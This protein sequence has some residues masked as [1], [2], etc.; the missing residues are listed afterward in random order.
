MV[1]E[2][3]RCGE[4][5]RKKRE[6]LIQNFDLFWFRI[7]DSSYIFNRFPNINVEFCAKGH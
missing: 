1:K 7:L 2:R 5:T 3:V 6:R 4:V